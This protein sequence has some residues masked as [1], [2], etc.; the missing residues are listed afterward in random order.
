MDDHS[1][2]S[3]KRKVNIRMN[4]ILALGES[5]VRLSTQSGYRLSDATELQL[6]Y[7]GAEA[8]VAIN[9][10][11]LD[12]DVKYATKLPSDNGLIN[13]LVSQ[14][15]GHG[16][17]CN[18]IIYG[19]GRLGSYYLEVGVGLRASNVIY[20]RKYSALS[21]ME[22]NEWDLDELFKDV[23]IFHITGVTLAISESWHEIGVK[24]I[25]EAKK[26]NIEIS[27]DMNYRQ[28]MWPYDIA[29]QTYAKVLPH[30][31][32]LSAG[33]RDAI[34]FMGISEVE[35]VEWEYY[36]DE[37]SKK[38]PN[39][40]YI[41]GTIRQTITPNSYDMYGYIWDGQ[42]GKGAI[43]EP[44][45]NH[46]VIDRVGTGD[47]Y[48]AAVLDGIVH[49]KPLK[50]IVDFGIA[51]SALKHTVYGDINPFSRAEIENFMTNKNDVNR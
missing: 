20:D 2:F 38:Y 18:N 1:S 6:H 41:F 4:K 36:L 13:S 46:T 24:L 15:Q 47:S 39:I 31:D 5:L 16:V 29:T 9:M 40:Q 43:S 37:I 30:V 10:A 21:L 51:A 44:S 7:G 19:K 26:R 22:A 8:N 25:E 45:A 17:D 48:T 42:K 33:K 11:Q 3:L 34:G 12:H 35:G 50:D 32:Y 49:R 14:L 28:K 27:F 23:S